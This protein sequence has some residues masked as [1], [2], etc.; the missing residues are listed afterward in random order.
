MGKHIYVGLSKHLART[1]QPT[2]I[3]LDHN[4]R[5][6]SKDTSTKPTK[7]PEHSAT[8]PRNTDEP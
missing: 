5:K 1:P 7:K 6:S 2:S 4:L 8:S 3:L